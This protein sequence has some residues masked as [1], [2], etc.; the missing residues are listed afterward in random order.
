MTSTLFGITISIL[1]DIG[2]TKCFV[3]PNVV[4][5]LPIR[6]GFMAE[7]WTIEYGNRVERQVEQCLFCS[8]LELPNFRSKVNLFC[9]SFRFL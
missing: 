2:A 7:P 4:A 6:V 3:D 8:E 5:R 9:S 1:V